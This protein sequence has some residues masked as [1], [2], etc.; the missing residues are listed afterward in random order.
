MLL[1]HTYD[2]HDTSNRFPTSFWGKGSEGERKARAV[3]HPTGQPTAHT[4][5]A[6]SMAQ[7]ETPQIEL[8]RHSQPSAL[9]MQVGRGR[10]RLALD[11]VQALQQQRPHERGRH[12]R[13]QQ[14]HALPQR[15]VGLRRAS[16]CRAFCCEARV[17][18]R[19]PY[20]CPAA[21]CTRAA[22]GG[23]PT[24]GRP[25][26]RSLCG[27][28]RVGVCHPAHQLRAVAQ[29]QVGLWCAGG[30]R[31]AHCGACRRAAWCS[32]RGA[33]PSLPCCVAAR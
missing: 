4:P 10:A 27:K 23:P 18:V 21:P 17:G 16:G 31:D 7:H 22:A 19:V 12:R 24:C 6:S 3:E 30:C 26:R 11:T 8:C 25:P 15:Q 5:H 29:W 32:A 20:P 2:F 33:R 1:L 14:L 28:G 9:Q 13:A